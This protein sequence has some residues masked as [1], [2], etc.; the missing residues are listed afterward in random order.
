MI[1]LVSLGG[2]GDAYLVCALARAVEAQYDSEVTVALRERQLA[3]PEMFG[4]R[5]EAADDEV[6]RAERSRATQRSYNNRLAAGRTFYA[7][8]CFT[9]SHV[10]LAELTTLP[11]QLSQA[12]VFRA[13]LGLPLDTPLEVPPLPTAERRENVA[14]LIPEAG[15]WPNDQPEFWAT[16]A[17]ELRAGGWSVEINDDASPL[18]DLLTF[19]ASA[20]MVAGPQCGVMSIP[21]AA[22]FPCRKVLCTPQIEE[23]EGFP[24]GYRRLRATFPYAYVTKFTGNDYDVDEYRIT[25][26]N[27]AEV[28]ES[29][30]AAPRGQRDPH[31]VTTVSVPLTPGDF[32]DRLAVLAVKRD[33]LG[34]AADRE[35]LRYREACPAEWDGLL[36]ELVNLHSTTFDQLA[37]TV[38][39]A[40]ACPERDDHVAVALNRTRVEL[41]RRIDEDLRAPYREI[42]SYYG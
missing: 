25:A 30:L 26:R 19:A 21:V 8:P 40:L 4:L 2:T 36:R 14:L 34:P 29:I 6:A 22:E 33:R 12:H 23:G 39:A 24:V 7:H 31:P 35:Y 18:A 15:S 32:L 16:L 17:Q 5:C 20:E 10:S 9:R 3:V 1:R 13:L 27:H 38:P 42:K 41:K 11:G 37:F 28:V